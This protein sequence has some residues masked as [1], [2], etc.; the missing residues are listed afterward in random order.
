MIL[1][2]KSAVSGIRIGIC[3]PI[4]PSDSQDSFGVD[5]SSGQ[6]QKRYKRNM[7]ML[8]KYLLDNYEGRASVDLVFLF[9]IHHM[10]DT[11]NSMQ[12]TIATVS[13]RST[14]NR[15]ITVA[16]ILFK[17]G[18]VN[19]I[20]YALTTS[21]NFANIRINDFLIVTGATNSANNGSFQ[22][23]GIDYATKTLSV[24]NTSRTTNALDEA[25]TSAIAS[26]GKTYI[27]Q[28]N[29]VH[30]DNSGYYAM[31]DGIYNHLK[32]HA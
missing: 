25:V 27:Q 30:P 31:A 18:S 24:I 32:K 14:T 16:S 8:Q 23:V 5:Y 19:T 26:T 3:I 13:D 17:T 20:D 21:L 11:A 1:K 2:I 10:L 29:S 6:T 9:P 12:T 28:N 15:A 4:P 7:Q 22:I